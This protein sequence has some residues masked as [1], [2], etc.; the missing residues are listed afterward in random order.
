VPKKTLRDILCLPDKK[1]EGQIRQYEAQVRG[2]RLKIVSLQK[3]LKER[4]HT[5]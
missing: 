4:Q 2:M 3:I 1:I 5:S